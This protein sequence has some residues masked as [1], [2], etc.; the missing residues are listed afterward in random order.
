MGRVGRPRSIDSPP[1]PECEA[2][3]DVASHGIQEIDGDLQ[4]AFRCSSCARVFVPGFAE[5]Q[6]SRELRQAVRR[7]RRE[8]EAPY[9]LIANSIEHQLGVSV[10][11]TTVRS[12]CDK[13]D[14]ASS[15]AEKGAEDADLACEYLSVLWALRHE[16]EDE[17]RADEGQ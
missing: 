8:T 15:E 9:R 17:A 2:T 6:P 3:D 16:I 4:R 14:G 12:W 1:C 13:Q 5:E 11:H 7:V 10:S